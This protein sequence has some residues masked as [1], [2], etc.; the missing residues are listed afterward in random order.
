M[1]Q[2]VP[3]DELGVFG[4]TKDIARA[5]SLL[6]AKMFEKRHDNVLA[7]IKNFDCSVEFNHLNFQEIDY[8]DDRG[9]K[10]PAVAMSRDGFMFLVMGYRGKKAAVVEEPD[11]V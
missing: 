1:K 8:R 9:R 10:Q 4:D 11:D 2:L 5:S 7:D 6:V 3:M